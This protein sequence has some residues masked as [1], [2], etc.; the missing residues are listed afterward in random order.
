MTA[1]LANV[2]LIQVLIVVLFGSMAQMVNAW[3]NFNLEDFCIW[4]C[5]ALGIVSLPFLSLI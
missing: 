3:S 5:V 4:T 1:L 2:I